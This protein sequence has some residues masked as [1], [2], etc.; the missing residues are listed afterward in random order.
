[1]LSPDYYYRSVT[2]IDLDELRAKG[3]DTLLVDLDNTLLPRKAEAI[4]PYASEWA[5]HAAEKGFKL[6][7]VSNNWHE[8]VKLF[9]EELGMQLVPKALKPLPFAFR[10]GL[11][12]TG[13][14]PQSTAIIGDQIFTDIL[15]GRLAGL[16]TV[17]VQPLSSSDL[18]HTLVLRALERRILAGRKPVA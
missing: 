16:T 11:R 10:A 8:Q 3:I 13:S 14:T 4:T 12:C 18:P 15:G 1:M 9:A 7:I 5:V 17:L 2:D 6:C